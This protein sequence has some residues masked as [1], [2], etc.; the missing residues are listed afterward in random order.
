MK[1]RMKSAS[2]SAVATK[3]RPKVVPRHKKHST[4]RRQPCHR[5]KRLPVPVSE[6][7]GASRL[8]RV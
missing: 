6:R 5:T 1:A 3:S 8:P 7:H 2:K 4:M